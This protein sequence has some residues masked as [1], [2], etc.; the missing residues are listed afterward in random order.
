MHSSSIYVGK[1]TVYEEPLPAHIELNYYVP[2]T[3]RRV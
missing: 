1:Y 3:K 2:A